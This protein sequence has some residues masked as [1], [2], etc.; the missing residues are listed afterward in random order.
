MSETIIDHIYADHQLLVNYLT[1]A[2]E[3]SFAY[4]VDESF[5]KS[6][7]LSAASLFEVKIRDC[8]IEFF[9]ERSGGDEVVLAFLKN[10]AIERQ[11]HTFFN[12]KDKKA[13]NFFG[14][15]GNG[16]L[17]YMGSEVKN[18]SILDASIS[19]FLELGQLR[20]SLVHQDYST[21]PLD[22]TVS[23]IFDLY[24]SAKIF[25]DILPTKLKAYKATK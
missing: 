12:W 23:E 21:F 22:K 8:L 13:N 2:G 3:T 7:L 24:E 17:Q 9:S 16:F 5:R 15:F 6:L 14:M 20:N 11:Y 25:V 1:D 18:D 4:T 10:K 19:A